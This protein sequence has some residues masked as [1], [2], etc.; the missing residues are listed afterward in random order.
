MLKIRVK[1]AVLTIKDFR[2]HSLK[3]ILLHENMNILYGYNACGKTSVLEAINLLI[4]TRSIKT[5]DLFDCVSRGRVQ[6]SI[7]GVFLDKK[8]QK[9]A[10]VLIS[11]QNRKNYINGVPVKKA[12]DYIGFAKVV[13]YTNN[14]FYDFMQSPSKRRDLF[15]FLIS[16]V[17]KE[18][19]ELLKKYKALI[20][21]KNIVLKDNKPLNSNKMLML[22]SYNEVIYNLS[23]ILSNK[24]KEFIDHLN[25]Y[26][27]SMYKKLEGEHSTLS[28]QISQ[29]VTNDIT[30]KRFQEMCEREIQIQCSVYGVH[31]DNYTI[32]LDTLD[33]SKYCSQGQV[34][35]ILICLKLAYA[36]LLVQKYRIKP[37]VLLD[38]I[39]GE[40]DKNRQNNILKLLNKDL[41]IIITTPSINEIEKEILLQSNLIKIE[42]EGK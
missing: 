42:K 9:K 11:K 21:E 41:Q 16:Q 6:T 5:R 7:E 18:Y 12:T 20:K 39:F 34:K 22:E 30:L 13:S 32:I 15:D 36:E 14:D 19:L 33:I 37:I 2:G 17:D 29:T 25:Y 4:T 24:R 3:T 38:D 26:I 31:R 35:S 28:I 1:I 40:L 8:S 10:L 27:N 23:K